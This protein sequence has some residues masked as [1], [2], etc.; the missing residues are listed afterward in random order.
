MSGTVL[1][2]VRRVAQSFNLWANRF[3]R[4]GLMVLSLTI[5]YVASQQSFFIFAIELVFNYAAVYLMQRSIGWK[6]T[7]IAGVTIAVDLVILIYFKYLDFIVREILGIAAAQATIDPANNL[8]FGLSNI[9][10]GISFYTFQMVA[11]VVDSFRASDDKI[12]RFVDYINFTSFFPQVV[13]GPIERRAD[14][15]PQMQSFRFQFSGSNFS[16]GMRW[17]ILGLFMKLVLSDNLSPYVQVLEA[18]NAWIIWLSVYLFSF[19]IYFDFAGYS[20]IALGLAQILGVQLT[21]NFQTPYVS[22]NI[23][24]FWRRWHISLSTWFRD[25]VYFP[26][27]GSRVPWA[28]ANLFTVFLISGLWHGA[29]WNFLFW[30]AYHGGLLVLHRYVAQPFSRVLRLSN[31]FGWMITFNL[32]TFGWLFFM[33]SD[34]ARMAAKLQALL[35]PA[36]YSLSN[37]KDLVAPVQRLS[38]G[39]I[40]GAAIA[41]LFVEHIAT[42]QKLPHGYQ[43]FLSSPV[44][45]FLLALLILVSAKASSKF[46]YFS[47]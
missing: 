15:L 46:I 43:L 37:L 47:F 3:D 20:L 42:L 12:L 35:T 1:L 28:A 7:A 40:V 14:L 25:Y 27:G 18:K 11:F 17:V 34:I 44:V 26:L 2:L 31:F 19:Q 30:G 9:P 22:T 41:F 39:V 29:G 4:V 45:R 13:A 10:P 38:L 32:V 36:A 6:R 23:Q 5:F 21:L 16:Q 24:E 33:E 8:S